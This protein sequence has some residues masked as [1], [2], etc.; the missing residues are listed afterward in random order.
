[1]RHDLFQAILAASLAGASCLGCDGDPGAAGDDDNDD[2][3][4]DGDSDADADGDSDADA[5]TDADCTAPETFGF[6]VMS[7]EKIQEWGGAEGLGGD[8]GGL[9]GADA[10]CQEAA[11]DVGS[12]RTWHAF[13]S[14]TD[15][16]SGSPVNAIDRIG[17]GPWYDINGYLLA[18]NVA[19]LL[20]TRPD[21]AT[22]PVWND[23]WNDW[24]FNKCLT[25]E[26]GNCNHSY[27][28]S[29]DTLT[30]SD[31]QGQ[32]VNADMKFTC[33]DWT[34]TDVNVQ[35]PIGHSWPRNLNDA[36]DDTANWILA[37]TNCT[38]GPGPNPGD[39]NGCGA[40]IN[41]GNTMEP[42]VGGDGGYGAW[43]C[44]AVD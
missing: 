38:T 13:L 20:H 19:G 27:G 36:S 41:I 43:Y 9:A 29:H 7:L 23:G 37:H 32:L 1:M 17:T 10:K 44:F 25:T 15:D 28:D 31:R 34:S 39:C 16:G 12:C 40:N 4:A 42:G 11:K 21:G 35:L 22:D 24:P 30:G 18:E 14:V 33:N 3:S 6:F 5:D 8:L 26:L 2:G